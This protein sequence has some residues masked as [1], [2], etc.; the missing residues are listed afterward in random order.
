MPEFK[1][2]RNLSRRIPA[3]VKERIRKAG[4]EDVDWYAGR[5]TSSQSQGF[6]QMSDKEHRELRQA[7]RARR[8]VRRGERKTAVLTLM[9]SVFSALR[10]WATRH[11][12]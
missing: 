5:V 1:Q 3:E 6:S 10:P 11:A 2:H 8:R 7:A 4:V 12:R 9:R